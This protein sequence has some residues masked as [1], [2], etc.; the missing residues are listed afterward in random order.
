MKYPP[1]GDRSACPLTR[2]ARF[3][4]M[5][6]KEYWQKANEDTLVILL[7]E[8]AEGMKNLPDILKVRGVD[9]IFFG[10]G[11]F[12]Q[13]IGLPGETYDHPKI[14]GALKDMV[15][16]CSEV[17]VS[18]MTVTIFKSFS[19]DLSNAFQDVKRITDAGVRVIIFGSEI[20]ILRQS[21]QA[22]IKVKE[23]M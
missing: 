6:Q 1:L 10:P 13:S 12:S 18:V 22:L 2:A 17:G 4:L 11:D 20:A 7:I 9:F 16:M 8:S 19:Y 14:Y 21:C 5:S 23:V 15:K 3:G